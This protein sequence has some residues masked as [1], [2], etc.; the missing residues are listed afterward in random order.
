MPPSQILSYSLEQNQYVV[1]VVQD[2]GVSPAQAKE[3]ALKQAAQKTLDEGYSYFSILASKEIEV[4]KVSQPEQNNVP[5]NLYQELI[6]EKQSGRKTDRPPTDSEIY[7]ALR[8]VIEC[9]HEKPTLRKSYKASDLL[10]AIWID[11][12]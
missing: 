9:Y 1:I 2:N 5:S 7:K 3:E 11:K 10:F 4:A 6:I 8:L 12:Y